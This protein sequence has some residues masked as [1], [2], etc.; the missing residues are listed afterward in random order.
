MAMTTTL[1]PRC[2]GRCLSDWCPRDTG[3]PAQVT[4]S[5]SES[6]NPRLPCYRASQSS[7]QSWTC[8]WA[9]E[10]ARASQ[11]ANL[12]GIITCFGGVTR[13]EFDADGPERSIRLRDRSLDEASLNTIAIEWLGLHWPAPQ[14]IPYSD[15]TMSA[16]HPTF[17]A[18]TAARLLSW[19]GVARGRAVD[20]LGRPGAARR[21]DQVRLRRPPRMPS[22]ESVHGKIAHSCRTLNP[23]SGD[24]SKQ[25][26]GVGNDAPSSKAF[27]HIMRHEIGGRRPASMP[28][29]VLYS[30]SLRKMDR[31]N[32]RLK[33]HITLTA[34][35][36][37]Y[38]A[39]WLPHF[40]VMNDLVFVGPLT[41]PLAWI[42]GLN[43]V[44]TGIATFAYFRFY[45]PYA[46][47][48]D[49]ATTSHKGEA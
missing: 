14:A 46:Q 42:L 11:A 22:D 2:Q 37:V 23:P 21:N 20:T 32:E 29:L 15:L 31:K 27:S 30:R 39:T 25:I 18:S 19:G 17:A 6:P 38:L 7:L 40:G 49:Q 4:S 45:K 47:R 12:R 9:T 48:M 41:Q 26:Q 5:C 8:P 24:D 16:A 44:S 33:H 35:F 3:M 1:R 10:V 34:F 36:M 43:L 28:S 13:A